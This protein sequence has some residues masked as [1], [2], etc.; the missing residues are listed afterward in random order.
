MKKVFLGQGRLVKSTV[1]F[2][3]VFF[4]CMVQISMASYHK[5]PD[6]DGIK[7]LNNG[8]GE[9]CTQT[10]L[11]AKYQEGCTV[12]SEKSGSSATMSSELILHVPAFLYDTTLGTLDVWADFTFAYKENGDLF[13]KLSDFGQN[14]TKTIKTTGVKDGECTQAELDAKY[15]EGCTACSGSFNTPATMSPELTLHI[16]VILY[17]TPLV[18]MN[19]WAT[20]TFVHKENNDLFWKLSDFAENKLL[21]QRIEELK[22][23]FPETIYNTIT[24]NSRNNVLCKESNRVQLGLPDLPNGQWYYTYDNLIKGMAQQDKFANVGDENTR[25]LEIAAFLANIAQ[26]TGTQ[27]AGDPFGGPGCFIQEGAGDYWGSNNFNQ[28]CEPSCAPEGYGGRGPHQLTWDYNYKE[29]GNSTGVGDEYLNDPDILT[30]NPEIGIAGSIWF[31]GHEE[32]TQW[33]PPNIPFKPSAHDVLVGNWIPTNSSTPGVVTHNDV[34]CGRTKANFG[35][36]INI[37]NG[38]LECGPGA[39][40]LTGAKNRVAYLQAIAKEMGVIIPDGFLDDCSTQEP[41]TPCTSY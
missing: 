38:G 7:Y 17:D 2:G 14:T 11:D 39:V 23:L 8:A 29:F 21:N 31:W 6:T 4:C 24:S 16:P 33:S 20:F 18:S 13:W 27:T 9:G 36:I 22:A 28:N 30:K 37:I 12:C 25:K 1:L 15:Q 35:V 32:R 10:E 5:L 41:F 40:N 26:E 3:I 34:D 19:L